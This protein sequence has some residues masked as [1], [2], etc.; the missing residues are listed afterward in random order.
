M[1]QKVL[2]SGTTVTTKWD[3]F[4]YYKMGQFYDKVGRV[5]QSGTM[6]TKWSLTHEIIHNF[7]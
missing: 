3:G 7:L 5:L 6:I 1:I 4:F 2:Q